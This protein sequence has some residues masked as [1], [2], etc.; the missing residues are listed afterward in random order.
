MTHKSRAVHPACR[1][2][3]DLKALVESHGIVHRAPATVWEDGL[4]LGNGD[5]A[6]MVHGEPQRARILLNK[7][8]IWDERADR[9]PDL[10]EF[11][12]WKDVKEALKK[13]VEEGDWEEY[14]EVSKPRFEGERN[15]NFASFQPAGYVE[16]LG[17]LDGGIEDFRQSLSLYRAEVTTRFRHGGREMGFATYAHADFNVLVLDCWSEGGNWP[18][19]LRLHRQL[20]PFF[21]RWEG[22]PEVDDPKFGAD[23]DSMWLTMVFPDGFAYAVVLQVPGADL[24]VQVGG[25]HITGNIGGLANGRRRAY[26]TIVTAEKGVPEALVQEGRELLQ[27]AGADAGLDRAH[28][29]WWRDFWH[30]GWISLP[31]ELVENLWYAEIYKVAS[32]SRPGGQAPGQLGHWSGYPDPPW[33]GDYHSNINVQ[34]N[35]WP[36]YTANRLELGEPFY[37]LYAGMLDGA[38]EEARSQGMP[39]ARYPRG[40]GKSGRSNNA[41]SYN[42]GIWPG[43]GPWIC[44]HF[45]WHYQGSRDAEF[46]RRHYP[47]FR[48]CLDFFLAYVGEKDADGYYSVVPSLCHEQAHEQASAPEGRTWGRNSPYDLALLREHLHNTL[49]ASEILGVDEGE[50]A[51][52]REVLEN[53]APYAV[54]EKG[55]LMEW[56]GI[57][58]DNSH[59]HHSHL[60]AIYPGEEIHQGSSAKWAE[61][62]RRSVMRL[63]ERG[64]AGYCGFSFGW[65]ACLAARMGLAD[66]AVEM[67]HNH[68][69]AF[70]NANGFSRILDTKVPGLGDYARGKGPDREGRQLP[71]MES[72]SGMAGAINELL[73]CSPRGRICV[74]PALPDEWADVRF[75]R[76][77]AQGAFLVSAEH[78]AG[79]ICYI[80]LESEAGAVCR[81]AH[82]WP[83]EE[84]V[85]LRG[86]E[87]A[88][89]F[90][91]SGADIVF[92]SAAGAWYLVYSRSSEPQDLEMVEWADGGGE[93]GLL[94]IGGP[95]DGQ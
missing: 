54:S 26:L 67:V 75:A 42:W 60:Y 15:G 55:Y 83:G 91:V 41:G 74:F 81:L 50:R 25:E 64:F 85:V 29:A 22:D 57:E 33:R 1:F 62:G 84:A 36:V 78:R 28:R 13:G 82:P 52:W 24:E 21:S 93:V 56:E 16:I 39:G 5:I 7:G 43:S 70:V 19:S 76:L 73:L 40:H 90:E 32:C 53:V 2:G 59:R 14:R 3:A 35:Y 72:G 89:D 61:I 11:W 17:N 87:E 47:M 88:V 65:L 68:I 30:R 63:I 86:G 12:N 49:A 20:I 4:Y 38:T 95:F 27:R 77:R 6:A 94:G 51:R 44:A 9:L 31:D 80:V 58:L 69:R 48:A 23:G 71:N 34:E 46:L 45:W 66:A 10:E 79:K 8:D 92:Q 37:D 18:L